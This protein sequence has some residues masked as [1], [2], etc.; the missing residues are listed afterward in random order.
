MRES[1]LNL[2]SFKKQLLIVISLLILEL[3]FIR[4]NLHLNTNIFFY[5]I[6]FY[7]FLVFLPIALANASPVILKK[8]FGEDIPLDFKKSFRKKRLFESRTVMG[9]FA[10][11]VISS[12]LGQILFNN[13]LLYGFLG[14][15]A[16]AGTCLNSFIKRQFGIPRGQDLLLLDQMDCLI[17]PF[18]FLISMYNIDLLLIGVIWF[19]FFHF[20]VDYIC[21][22][23]F[24]GYSL[25][26]SKIYL[27]FILLLL[28]ILGIF[29]QI[30]ANFIYILFYY[31]IYGTSFAKTF[32]FVGFLLICLLPFKLNINKKVVDWLRII[33]LVF[34]LIIGILHYQEALRF[35]QNIGGND[36][37][38]GQ[39]LIYDGSPLK[40]SAT[41]LFH[42]H[43][44]KSF[45]SF[46]PLDNF[47]T[48]KDFL[49]NNL[50]IFYKIGFVL[51]F[52]SA[53]IGLFAI[54]GENDTIKRIKW[55]II[56]FGFL[57]SSI[58]G[59]LATPQFV[60]FLSLGIMLLL[61]ERFPKKYYW[62]FGGIPL[63]F[64]IIRGFVFMGYYYPT[65]VEAKPLFYLSPSIFL[66]KKRFLPLLLVFLSV[67]SLFHFVL[68]PQVAPESSISFYG[69]PD[70]LLVKN[71]LIFQDGNVSTIRFYTN[72][73]WNVFN[74]VYK[75]DKG[76]SYDSFI[77]HMEMC[78]GIKVMETNIHP[79]DSF[80]SSIIRITKIKKINNYLNMEYVCGCSDC[81]IIPAI[82]AKKYLNKNKM[83]LVIFYNSTRDHSDL[84]GVIEEI[85][86][87]QKRVDYLA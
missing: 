50:S 80:N 83:E 12:L 22:E 63:I 55:F 18:I 65:P 26:Y 40:Y 3:L 44:F 19:I 7:G 15:I 61:S 34:V 37:S 10:F 86:P 67:L 76:M 46:V 41:S 13:P 20:C 51:F 1:K 6:F 21:G 66:T 23:S 56:S 8:I 2:A 77:S 33:F 68:T 53:L 49:P 16:F 31:I 70:K 72:D 62:Y 58:D 48:G 71:E 87:I 24:K 9:M 39:I 29:T 82:A 38:I 75:T 5:N 64:F 54:L 4:F 42:S 35:N 30:I 59:G 60:L 85:I 74:E 47:D 45:F 81:G 11:I 32:L 17:L 36:N 69:N 84:L 43:L 14:L 78:Y 25:P 57:I 73:S 27:Y 52:I 79:E 28:F